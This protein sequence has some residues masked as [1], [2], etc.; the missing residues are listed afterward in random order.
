MAKMTQITI[1]LSSKQLR[2]LEKMVGKM[3]LDRSQVIRLAIA[4]L[5]E[6][7]A[8]RNPVRS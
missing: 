3:A 7:E 4:R 2:Q 8:N 5:A 6:E 1:K